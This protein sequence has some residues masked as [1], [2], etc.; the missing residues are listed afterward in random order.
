[1][2]GTL[3]GEGGVQASVAAMLGV[4]SIAELVYTVPNLKTAQTYLLDLMFPNMIES[5]APEIAID[6]DVGKRRM[7]AFCSPL[8]EGK[9]VESRQWV[10]NLFK[11]PY[12]KDLRNPDL[13]RPVRRQIGERIGGGLTPQER[14]DANLAW[15][16]TDQLDM[17]ER[18]CEW[19]AASALV[20]GTIIVVGEGYPDPIL[21]DFNRDPALTVALSG[22]AQWGQTGVYPSDY[23]TAWAAIVLQK[24]GAA[25]T[26][27]IFT[28][29]SWNAFKN[30]VKVLNS[31]IWPGNV[32]GSSLDLGGRIVKGGMFMGRWGQFNLHLYNDW[33][34]DPV[35]DVEG[36]MIP[37][38]TVIL[39]G[40]GV[41][42][43]RAYGQI[44]DPEFAYGPM[45]FAPKIWIE[46]NPAQVNMLMQSAPVMIPSRVNASMAATV[47][48]PGAGV[49]GPTG[50]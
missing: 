3:Q 21:I 29:S 43:T 32:G 22:A 33:V 11:P 47:M 14:L 34:V 41:E 46:K 49:P 25:P 36:P 6:V 48:A 17:I 1:M 45:A 30:D 2:S 13:L 27:I 18:R 31:I 37:D 24:S 40:P 35:T 10:T 26:D 12:I 44:M 42:G 19:M 8:V 39:G 4:Y 7:A 5:D 9:P 23:I 20:N 38:G 50:V 28:N 16:L 15:E